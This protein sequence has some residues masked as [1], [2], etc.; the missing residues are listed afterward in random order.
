MP[1]YV[2]SFLL[3]WAPPLIWMALIFYGSSQ[4]TLPAL[5]DSF[6]DFL[7][8]NGAHFMEYAVLALLWYRAIYSR[9]P[10]PRIQ[11]LAFIIV[12]IYA[13]SDEFH[14]Y[15]VPGRSATWQDVAID[16]IGGACALLFWNA[17]HQRWNQR[18]A[19]HNEDGLEP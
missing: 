17:V 6:L 19:L 11:P 14:Q 12:V 2:R 1:S 5:S 18:K 15:F 16:V 7:I 4:P 10:D 13:L 9:F 3:Y 8:K